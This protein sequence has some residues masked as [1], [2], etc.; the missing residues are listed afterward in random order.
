[1]ENN[2]TQEQN[3]STPNL[4]QGTANLSANES[5]RIIDVYNQVTK[6]ANELEAKTKDIE[7]MKAI[8]Y[9]GFVIVIIMVAGIFI[10]MWNTKGVSNEN[11]A[12][13]IILQNQKLDLIIQQNEKQEI[14]PVAT[15]STTSLQK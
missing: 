3:S 9:L 15:K 13:Q 8:T 7:A 6:L 14:S 11:L 5:K 2:L 1:M 10:D 12:G 4:V